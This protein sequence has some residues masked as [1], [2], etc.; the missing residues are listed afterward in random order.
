MTSVPLERLP[1]MTCAI[2]SRRSRRRTGPPPPR[3]AA[4]PVPAD[5][6]TVETFTVGGLSG[7]TAYYFAIKSSDASG[8]GSPLSNVA[9]TTTQPADL[10]PPAV[11]MNL[12]A[13]G[14]HAHRLTL[15]W[16]ATGDDGMNGTAATYDIRVSTLPITNDATFAAA[17]VLPGIPVPATP[18]SLQTLA[19]A[20]LAAGT[21]YWF[22]MKVI[23]EWPN[24]SS[25]SDVVRVTTPAADVTPTVNVPLLVEEHNGLASH[26]RGRQR[27]RAVC[28]GHPERLYRS[29]A[30]G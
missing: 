14:V 1:R 23:D 10:I 11:V 21:T 13:A 19:V 3:S 26:C 12:A 22:A 25:L 28:D 2:R 17:T 16:K 9:S 27:R 29:A 5:A 30:R 15:S 24:A 4:K 18:G 20:N 7:G 8:N 6:G